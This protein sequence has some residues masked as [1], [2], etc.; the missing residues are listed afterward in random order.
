MALVTTV[1]VGL[2]GAAPST[3]GCQSSSTHIQQPEGSDDAMDD[4]ALESGWK[5]S[6]VPPEGCARTGLKLAEMPSQCRLKRQ[7]VPLNTRCQL[8]S[9]AEVCTLIS[10]T[11]WL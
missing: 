2:T 11:S 3:A 10:T 7:P 6:P 9:P 4:D 5:P 8:T 1:A